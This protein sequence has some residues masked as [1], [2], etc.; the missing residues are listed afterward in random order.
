M[1]AY[2]VTAEG[3]RQLGMEEARWRSVTDAVNDVLEHA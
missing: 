2:E 3:R 1:T